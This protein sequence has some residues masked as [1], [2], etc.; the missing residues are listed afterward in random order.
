MLFRCVPDTVIRARLRKVVPAACSAGPLVINDPFKDLRGLI[1]DTGVRHAAANDDY[2]RAGVEDRIPF[3]H[4]VDSPGGIDRRF[5]HARSV[6]NRH[7]AL[8]RFCL[9][10][11]T[12]F[13]RL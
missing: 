7:V 6:I 10:P 1:H 8:D 9:G 11:V 4:D 13:C 5:A 12:K 2:A 3:G